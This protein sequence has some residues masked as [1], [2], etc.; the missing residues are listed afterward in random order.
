MNTGQMLERI[1]PR[2]KVAWTGAVTYD[3]EAENL[4]G[5]RRADISAEK[6][7]SGA[8][9]LM[10]VIGAAKLLAHRSAP[11]GTQLTAERSATRR[12]RS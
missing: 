1:P 10:S 12:Q 6:A 7:D 4:T 8:G 3:A 5:R 11:N 9:G 2:V